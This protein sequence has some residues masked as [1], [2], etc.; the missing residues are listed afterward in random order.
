MHH[1]IFSTYLSS[2]HDSSTVCRRVTTCSMPFFFRCYACFFVSG[3]CS[4]TSD[5]D[6]APILSTCLIWNLWHGCDSSENCC[7]ERVCTVFGIWYVVVVAVVCLIFCYYLCPQIYWFRFS[8][9][10][11]IYRRVKSWRIT[12]GGEKARLPR[13][14]RLVQGLEIWSI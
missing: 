7:S 13:Y 5:V 4:A 9:T 8:L 12:W 1:Y 6:T 11:T 10:I 14:A 3:S 2:R